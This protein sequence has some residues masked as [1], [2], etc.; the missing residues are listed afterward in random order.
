MNMHG[1]HNN[2]GDPCP[3][4][5]YGNTYNQRIL[6]TWTPSGVTEWEGS[7]EEMNILFKKLPQGLSDHLIQMFPPDILIN[8]SEIYL[9]LGQIPECV[10]ANPDN[11]G[12]SE[13]SK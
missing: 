10:V 3:T 4:Y 8:L 1:G 6:R 9:Q 5:A 11:G 12:K 7:R 2:N 13:R